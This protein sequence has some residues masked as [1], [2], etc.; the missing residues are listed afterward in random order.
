MRLAV[1][2]AGPAGL[3]LS[4]LMARTSEHR[5]TVFERN[6]EGATYGWG[7]VFS[8]GTLAELAEVDY[9]TYVDLNRALVRWSA[10]DIRHRGATVRSIGHGFSA[11]SRRTLLGVLLHRARELGVDVHFEAEMSPAE[12]L[13]G[14]YDLVVAA[15]GV[16][17]SLRQFHVENFGLHTEVHPTRYIWLGLPEAFDAFTFIFE[18]TPYGLF[19]VHGYPYDASGSTFIVETTER[20]WRQAGL[21]HAD[22]AESVAFCEKV[23]ADHLD[24]APLLSNRSL[25]NAFV[26]VRNNTWHHLRGPGAPVV[27]IGDA[28]HTAHFSI[29]SGT[30]LAM[31]DA[32]SLY[33]ALSAYPDLATALSIYEADRQPPVA[34]FQEAARDSAHYFEGVDQ[35]LDLGVET[36]AFNL[37]TRSGRVTRIDM[38]RR[39]PSLTLAA[40][41]AIAGVDRGLVVAAPSQT[42]ISIGGLRLDNRMVAI[43][44]QQDAHGLVMTPTWS[45]SPEGRQHPGAPTMGDDSVEDLRAQL[46]EIKDHN[47]AAGVVIGHAGPRASCLTPELGL[48]RPLRVNGW[49]ILSCSPLPY[50]SSQSVPRALD[51]GDMKRITGAFQT[52]AE[53]GVVAEADLLL[54]DAAHGHLLATFISPLTNRR[55]DEY[56]GNLEGRMRFPLEVMA[57]VRKVWKGPLG[58]RF[59][60]TD[61]AKG[62]TTREEAVAIARA[63]TGAGADLI[64]VAGGGTTIRAEPV[65]RR[66]FLLGLASEIKHRAGVKVLVGGGIISLDDADTAIAAGRADL[67]RLNPYLYRRRYSSTQ[68]R[69]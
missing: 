1:S 49:E 14:P 65:Y 45:V 8:E 58:V 13:A 47:S 22:E 36:F 61:W 24:G 57:A 38:E 25:W 5:I 11:I 12:I 32:A 50:V 69:T 15:D 40:D 52:A 33:R 34:R 59:S 60:A 54:V 10:I 20:N 9:L 21:H 67:I 56:G 19:Q 64:E 51:A 37:L 2:G 48:D 3:Y 63:F 26:T 30:K 44:G 16:N 28:A 53:F 62:G 41:R 68:P 66:N 55:Q 18:E 27:L 39:D 46:Q 23:F 7:V 6:S 35:Y 4:L 29:G 17:S 42:P 43:A 31:E